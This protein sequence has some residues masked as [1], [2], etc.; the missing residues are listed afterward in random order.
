VKEQPLSYYGLLARTRLR[1]AREKV[2]VTWPAGDFKLPRL[3]R[4]AGK[5]AAVLRAEDLARAG[6][7]VDAG[8]ELQRSENALEERLGKDQALTLLFERYPRYQAFRRAYQLADSRAS[9]AL[10]A[11]PRGSG[12][13]AWEAFY[14]RAYRAEVEKQAR[15]ARVPALFVFAIMHKE[16]E[17]RPTVTSPADARG[18]LQLLPSLG[19]ELSAGQRRPFHPEDLFR[20]E[21]NIRLGARRLGSLLEM[22]GGQ[23]FLA[24]GAYNGGIV[25][26][27]RWLEQQGQRPLDEFLEL[28]GVNESREY[29]KRVTA[30]HARYTY[31]YTGKVLELPLTV[32]VPKQRAAP[33]RPGRKKPPAAKGPPP[34]PP[35][36]D[37]PAP[38]ESVE[39]P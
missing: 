1:Q 22:F 32:K 29:M 21:V 8:I 19:A 15:A 25:A 7:V 39:P 18:L 20:P 27:R 35:S 28:V 16:S 31:L 23:L 6:L 37:D 38:S 13:V 10:Q 11:E 24:A 30:L 12:R 14:P 5:D 33:G 26:A 4:K 36:D 34:S 17:F 3:G 9:A 2:Q